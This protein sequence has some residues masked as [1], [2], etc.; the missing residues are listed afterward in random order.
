MRVMGVIPARYRS[1]RFPGKVLADIRG[2]PMVVRIY[3]EVAKSRLIDELVVATDD[4]RVRDVVRGYGGEVEMTPADCP[5]GSDRVAMV[6]EDKDVDIVVNIQSDDPL[7]K[8]EMVDSAIEAMLNE[9]NVDMV[10]LAKRIEREDEFTSANTVKVVFDERHFALYFS[11]APIPYPRYEGQPAYKHVGPYVYRKEFLLKFLSW[12]PTPLERTESLEQLRILEKG[13]RIKI[14]ETDV[15]TVEVDV[16]ED[17][18]RVEAFLD[19]NS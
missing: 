12:E 13:Y 9:S 19:A 18:K 1:T 11:R 15:E 4:E 8:V 3:K 7:V 17:L 6:V 5:S 14:V 2:L 16:P 10:A